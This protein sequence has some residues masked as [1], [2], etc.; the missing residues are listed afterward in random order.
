MLIEPFAQRGFV[1]TFDRLQL[2]LGIFLVEFQS[3][4]EESNGDG[5][6]RRFALVKLAGRASLTFHG[7]AGTL[8]P[9][10]LPAASKR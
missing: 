6:L 3:Q 9:Q 4:F 7:A 8:L 10:S 1:R 2:S 5:R